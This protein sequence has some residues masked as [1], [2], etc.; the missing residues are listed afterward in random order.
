MLV[1]SSPTF[2]TS[3]RSRRVTRGI[4]QEELAT[5]IGMSRRW[6][7]EVEAGRVTPTLDAAIKLINGLGLELHLKEPE[8]NTLFDQ[9]FEELG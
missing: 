9:I 3:V 7:Q 4:T 6:V 8:E 2:A 5:K 1:K